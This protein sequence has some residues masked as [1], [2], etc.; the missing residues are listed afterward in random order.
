MDTHVFNKQKQRLDSIESL[1]VCCGNG[2]SRGEGECQLN[3]VRLQLKI[4]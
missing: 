2:I 4:E 1:C 3:C